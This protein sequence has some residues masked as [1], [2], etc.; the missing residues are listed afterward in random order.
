MDKKIDEAAL[1]QKLQRAGL[2]I[3]RPRLVLARLLFAGGN[4][5]VTADILAREVAQNGLSI[6]TATIYNTLNQFRACKLLREV[7]VDSSCSYFDTNLTAHHHFYV[8]SEHRLIDIEAE[9]ITLQKM[10]SIPPGY[11]PGDVDIII[12]LQRA[13]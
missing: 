9:H 12:H 5:H 7:I 4:R 11:T 8:K 1:V 2:R 13:K 10:P 3:T 6:S